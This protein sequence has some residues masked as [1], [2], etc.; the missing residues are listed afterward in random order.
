[1]LLRALIDAGHP[2]EAL[3]AAPRPLGVSETDIALWHVRAEAAGAVLDASSAVEAWKAIASAC[4]SDPRAWISL[5]RTLLSMN[6]FAEAEKAYETALELLPNN[7]E[8]LRELGMVYYRTTQFDRLA[9][10]LDKADA[11]R[12]DKVS[13]SYLWAARELRQGNTDAAREYL[14]MTSPTEDPAGWYR[15]KA[16]I[17]E[18]EGDC[19][20]AFRAAEAM[21]R[22][23]PQLDEWRR[24]GAIHR[25]GLRETARGMG[26]IWAARMRKLD[27]G[28]RHSPSF[29]VGFPRSGTTLLDTFLMGHPAISIVEEEGV[30]ATTAEVAGPL[31]NLVDQPQRALE[32][33]RQSYFRHLDD[34]IDTK[35]EGLVVEKDP[36][37]M[38]FAP[39]IY[40][41]FGETPIIFAQ[42]HPCDVVLSAYMQNF[43]PNLGMSSFFDLTD[44]ADFYDA[45]M[46]LWTK[47]R[48]LLPLNVHVV[49]YEKVVEDPRA[50]LQSTID[51][52]GLE[53]DDQLLNHVA[54]AR[55]RGTLLNTSYDQVVEPL[56]SKPSGR[57]RRYR[58]QLDP[59]LPLL[60]SWAEQLGYGD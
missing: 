34:H 10:L 3:K 7:V 1:M 18:A 14:M 13:L 47:S 38:L 5:G 27:T 8:A 43:D 25:A 53:W 46:T 21:N 60:L 39:L 55:K 32:H 17:A 50:E 16:R 6:C 49:A 57:W 24:R 41:L 26:P 2:K 37:N 30:L 23:T 12:T 28:G 45:A 54:T 48:E 31:L 52:I 9:E 40:A 59:V 36:L 42:R 58:K 4:P 11:N 22:A 19:A 44:A 35:F 56:S 20:E 33:M 15:L 51:F 29:L